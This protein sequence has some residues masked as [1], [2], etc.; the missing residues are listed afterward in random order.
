MN[1]YEAMTVRELPNNSARVDRVIETLRG[2]GNKDF[3]TFCKMLCTSNEAVWADE[4]KRVAELFKRGEGNILIGGAYIVLTMSCSHLTLIHSVL[5]FC[6][7]HL[8]C[9]GD[10]FMLI[11]LSVNVL[12]HV[13]ATF[14]LGIEMK[15]D[16]IS[17]SVNN[18]HLR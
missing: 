15:C 3:K 11:W 16:F 17:S 1:Q 8:Q 5:H 2:K 4:L 7:H 6:V 10:T 13:I 14:I 9:P 12:L 18:I